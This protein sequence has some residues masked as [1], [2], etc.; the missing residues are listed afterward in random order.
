MSE[1]FF[2]PTVQG[3][4]LLASF[5]IPLLNGFM[6]S[7]THCVGMC[8]PLQY[9]VLGRSH[10][11]YEWIRYHL[12]RTLA[13]GLMGGLTATAG[14][15]IHARNFPLLQI[16]SKV[17]LIAILFLSAI[18]FALGLEGRWEK[19]LSSFVPT[20]WLY[21]RINKQGQ[22]RMLVGFWTGFLP[23]PTT[24]ATLLWSLSTGKVW[25]GV[26]GMFLFGLATFPLFYGVAFLGKRMQPHSHTLYRYVT[27]SLFIGLAF[28]HAYNGFISPHP[29]CH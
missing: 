6:S 21:Q 26:I 16:T 17:L 28:W 5:L 23:C 24:Y 10:T 29:S 1:D 3:T 11:T 19:W 9:V 7:V 27:A 25:A 20:R 15:T 14:L 13:Y 8:A 12:G 2:A 18:L 22:S 4:L